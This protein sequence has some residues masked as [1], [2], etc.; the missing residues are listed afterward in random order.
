MLNL[1]F[2]QF[3]FSLQRA[4]I[5]ARQLDLQLLDHVQE[6]GVPPLALYNYSLFLVHLAL[7]IL[8]AHVQMSH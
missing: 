2:Q 5:H 7:Q 6:A 8:D 4:S 1:L 3:N